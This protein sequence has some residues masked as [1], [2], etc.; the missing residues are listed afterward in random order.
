PTIMEKRTLLEQEKNLLQ[1][2]QCTYV[3]QELYK[4]FLEDNDYIIVSPGI[5]TRPYKDYHHKFISE[6]DIF[7]HHC[8]I[9]IIAITGTVGKTSVTTLLS[10][11]L[12]QHRPI[13]T[14]GNI[15]IGMLE[16]LNNKSHNENVVL[17]ISS[18]Q[19]EHT[20]Y[21][22]PDVAILTNFYPNHLDRHATVENYFDAKCKLFM[23]QKKHQ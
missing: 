16:L 19:L 18:F 20:R 14:G 12:Q 4:N 8:K 15:G 11:M 17:E 3:P 23:R 5:D 22:A 2:A 7:F 1:D 21:F 10:K 6:L 9:P 13:I